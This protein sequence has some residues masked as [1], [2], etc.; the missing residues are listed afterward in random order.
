MNSEAQMGG[1]T[2]KVRRSRGAKGGKTA[3]ASAT[4]VVE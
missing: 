4:G 1:V 2:R 3:A